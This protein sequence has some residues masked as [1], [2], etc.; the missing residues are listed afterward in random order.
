MKSFFTV[1]AIFF[2]IAAYCQD[3]SN[4]TGDWKR[5]AKKDLESQKEVFEDNEIV[6]GELTETLSTI[7]VTSEREYDS[8]VNLLRYIVPQ[9]DE[10]Y[11]KREKSI[12]FYEIK[13]VQS[14]TLLAYF[15]EPEY[16]PSVSER[17]DETGNE[18]TEAEDKEVYILFGNGKVIRPSNIKDEDAKM[19]LNEFFSENSESHLGDFEIPAHRQKIAVYLRDTKKSRLVNSENNQYT[20]NNIEY[21]YFENIKISIREGGIYDIRLMMSDE[22]NIH[23]YYFSNQVPI[24]L[25]RYMKVAS[26]SYLSNTINSSNNPNEVTD[27]KYKDYGVILSDVLLYFNTTGNNFV[28][29]DEDY[30]F[31]PV[32]DVE[33]KNPNAARV[34]KIKQDTNLQ[35]ILELRTYTDFLGLFDDDSPNGLVQIEGRA[36]FYIAPFQ[37]TPVFPLTIFK[38]A[39]PYVNFARI[40]EE[41]REVPLQSVD[42][43]SGMFAVS[44][45]LD[46]IERAYLDMGVVTDIIGFSITKEFPFSVNTY[47]PIRYKVAQLGWQNDE[48]E[49]LDAG[50]NFKTI[51]TGVGVRIE[52]K[53]F[54]NFGFT[55]SV[56]WIN[57]NHINKFET[58]QMPNNFWVFGNESEIFYY[59]NK[60]KKQSIFLRLRSYLN[61]TDGEDSFFQ[62]QFG[63]RFAIGLSKK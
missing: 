31:P 14:D 51:G 15:P 42:E 24:S 4:S 25:L 3:P 46:L 41:L 43:E 48:T 23:K 58:L 7:S 20:S 33:N 53:R 22:K 34:Y 37:L 40:D 61:N 1:A 38:K 21:L 13:G 28:P 30:C 62:L 63:Y 11:S 6:Y 2:C 36:D 9:L 18:A 57:Y 52:V 29:D 55:H 45:P 44:R 12:T 32:A 50:Q 16:T 10:L 59:P 5:I 56:E 26:R 49:N 60:S 19:I 8:I 54:N 35:N 17:A 47:I 39:M 27:T